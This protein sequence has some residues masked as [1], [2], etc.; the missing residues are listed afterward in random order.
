MGV[1]IALVIAM[2]ALSTFRSTGIS[3]LALPSATLASYLPPLALTYSQ[4]AELNTMVAA[5]LP[6]ETATCGQVIFVLPEP[7]EKEN[8][9]GA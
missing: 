9:S 5:A 8:A 6:P 2:M 4:L 1:D 3:K 7:P